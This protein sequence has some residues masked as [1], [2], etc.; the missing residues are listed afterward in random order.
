M[1][2][3]KKSHVAAGYRNLEEKKDYLKKNEQCN[4][5]KLIL[6]G[7]FALLWLTYFEGIFLGVI[8]KADGFISAIVGYYLHKISI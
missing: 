3:R 7:F 1:L 4:K 6:L 8:C 5:V 2:N